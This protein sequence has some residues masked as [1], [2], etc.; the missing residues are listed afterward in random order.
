MPL[1]ADD[2]PGRTVG[3]FLLE[4]LVGQGGFAWVVAG[5]RAEGGE[6]VALKILKPRY[7]GDRQFEQRF[8]NEFRTAQNLAHPNIVRIHD[9]GQAGDITY[10][11]MDLYPDS[12]G[13]LLEREGPLA[14]ARVVRIALDVL[15]GLAYAHDAG[16]VHRDIK[17]DNVL[18]REDG[19]AVIADFGIA[20]A[21]SGYATAT[22]VN[23]TIGT[24]A[25][26]SPEQA[27]GRSLDGRSDL[28]ALGVLL[29][30]ALTGALPFNS[31]DWFELARM[32]VEDPPPPPRALR[33]GLSGRMER[34]ILRCLAKHPDDR[35]PTAEALRAELEAIERGS[36]QTADI[37][38]PPRRPS[39]LRRALSGSTLLARQVPGWVVAVAGV[40]VVVLVAL[41]V[42]WLGR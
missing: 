3:P 22:G 23:M 30:R 28:Y 37:A 29:Y 7:A 2:L 18:L 14:E 32:H 10:F 35:Y 39:R 24:P 17:I 12:L 11:A 13:S 40:M 15:A 9:V 38:L 8:R 41:V 42:V 19:T 21:V 36:R 20:R 4:H 16:I 1:E 31:R 33:P 34:V 26:V 6:P 25:Y 27:Q 5:R